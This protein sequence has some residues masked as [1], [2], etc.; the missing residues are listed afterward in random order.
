VGTEFVCSFAEL[1][2]IGDALRLDVRRF[3]FT[4]GYHGVT[5]EERLALLA[6]AH[7]DLVAR[8]LIRDGEFTPELV[9][10]LRVFAQGHLAIAFVGTTG[11]IHRTALSSTDGRVGVLA[12]QQGESIAF[13]RIHPDMVVRRLVGVLPAMRPGPGTSV[14]ISDTSS[15]TRPSDDDFSEFRFTSRMKPAPSALAV[16]TDITRRTR[17][18]AGYFTITARGRNDR[19]TELGTL[20]YLDTDAGRYAVIPGTDPH[21]R[22][23]A[24]YTPADQAFLDRQLTR[25]V[26]S[27]R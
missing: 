7:R 13:R 8:Q 23:S 11:D 19:E 18:G 22:M 3:P 16:A 4:I 9:E 1:D 21:G 17:L 12:E 15:P 2:V 14:T 6:A 25:I 26:D 5:R 24:T 27:P 10:T 20:T